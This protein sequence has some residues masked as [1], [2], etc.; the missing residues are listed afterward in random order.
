MHYIKL[1]S[2][3]NS[4]QV[5]DLKNRIDFNGS[6]NESTGEPEKILAN[7]KKASYRSTAWIKNIKL[8]IFPKGYIELAGSLH[9]H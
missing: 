5:S 6:Y 1:S 4:T 7:G 9:R 2:R 3:L 8:D